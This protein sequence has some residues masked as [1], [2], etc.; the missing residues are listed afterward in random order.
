M[1]IRN[2]DITA[3]ILAGG[4]GRRMGG[5]DKGLIEF[6]GRLMIEILIEALEN[7][8]LDI[9]INANRNQSTYQTYGYPVVSDN[10]DNFQGDRKSTRL[11]SSH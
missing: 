5:Q 7:Q 11:N 6:E 2:S 1:S 8:R 3:V 4:Q 9:V 10:L